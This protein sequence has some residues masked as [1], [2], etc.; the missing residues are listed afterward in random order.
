M[1]K[2]VEW[3]NKYVG[4]YPPDEGEAETGSEDQFWVQYPQDTVLQKG[5][6]LAILYRATQL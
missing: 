2:L 5:R 3:T 6:A 1:D 4:L